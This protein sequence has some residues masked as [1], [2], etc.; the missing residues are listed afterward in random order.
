[1][2]R[3]ARR[4]PPKILPSRTRRRGL[5]GFRYNERLVVKTLWDMQHEKCCYCEMKIP[6]QGH[7]KAVEHFRPKSKFMA[8]KNDWNNLLLACAQCNGKK[9]DKFPLELTREPNEPKVLHTRYDGKKREVKRPLLVDPTREDPE[10]FLD[11]VMDI[12]DEL[13]GQIM[14]RNG[15]IRGKETIRVI[16]L[17]DEFYLNQHRMFMRDCLIPTYS[18]LT[19]A[20]DTRNTDLENSCT[21]EFKKF[22]H[23]TYRFAAVAR[24]FARHYKLDRYG[25]KIP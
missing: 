14:P 13:F 20:R 17:C 22:M 23:E 21:R 1:M 15:N 10:E 16:G 19:S 18:Q 24:A 11:F 2:I 4:D 7:L 8:L 5:C 6:E 9:S 12:S 25:I 3:I